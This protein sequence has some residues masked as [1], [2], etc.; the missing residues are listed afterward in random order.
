MVGS[1]W[2]ADKESSSQLEAFLILDQFEHNDNI[3]NCNNNNNKKFSIR[4]S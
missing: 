3:N 4:D 1:N 2:P